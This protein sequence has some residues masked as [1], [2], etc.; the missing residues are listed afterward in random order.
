MFIFIFYLFMLTYADDIIDS[1][2]MQMRLFFY[3]HLHF[4]IKHE[5]KYF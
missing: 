3:V 5:K 2:K 4:D 1:G